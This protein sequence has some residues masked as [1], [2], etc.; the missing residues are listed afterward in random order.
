MSFSSGRRTRRVS[1]AEE[2]SESDF[3]PK[4]DEGNAEEVQQKNAGQTPR[5]TKR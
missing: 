4:E 2:S 3:E 1:Y 5:G